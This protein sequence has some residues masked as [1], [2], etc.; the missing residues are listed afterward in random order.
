MAGGR[1]HSGW[2]GRTRRGLLV[3]GL[4]L[5]ATPVVSWWNGPWP[6]PW[7]SIRLEPAVLEPFVDGLMGAQISAYQVPGAVVAVVQ[8]GEVL[9][10]KGYGLARVVSAT[11]VRADQTLF[12]VGSVAKVLTWMALLQLAESG[13]LSL[14]QD[15][16]EHLGDLALPSTFQ[17]PI[18]PSH[19]MTHTAGFED[20]F[21]GIF[22]AGG[23]SL[24]P[25]PDYL[26]QYRPL[27][28]RPPGQLTAYSNYGAALA[29]HLVER[30][31]GL[32]FED[33]V[34]RHI[35]QPLDML[36]ST[37]AQP[38][39][40][41]LRAQLATGYGR[42]LEPLGFEWLQAAPSGALSTT[43]A[44]MA[45]LMLTVLGGGQLGEARVLD[46]AWVETMLTRQFT[47]DPRLPG[48]TFAFQ[49]YLLNGQR[50]LW[51]PGDTLGFSSALVLVP[52]QR[53]GIFIAY[54]RLADSQPRADFL[55]IF[56]D[57]FFPALPTPP[58]A[59]KGA[60]AGRGVRYAGSYLPSRSNL[61][62][63]EKVF[64]LFRPVTVSVLPDGRLHTEGLWAVKEGF[65]LETEPG[66]YR[67]TAGEGV[68][69]FREQ[70][71]RMIMLEGNYPQGAYL[72]V[73][74]YGAHWLHGFT[75]I[76]AAVAFF[77]TLAAATSRLLSFRAA[78]PPASL[79][80][81][82][83]VV[84]V[85]SLVQLG[86]LV[87][88][89]SILANLRALAASTDRLLDALGLLAFLGAVMA[90]AAAVAQGALWRPATGR[91]GWRI[92]YGMVVLLG[93]L[94]SLSL[95]YWRVL[96]VPFH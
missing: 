40:K 1:R 28:V 10:A 95:A 23:G 57:R 6:D 51:H 72:R 11:P 69:H 19:L 36:S 61:S 67:H 71:D 21:G 77:A 43:A 52:D 73:P 16:N 84:E 12:R 29:G 26:R 63:P 90:A 20:R 33:Y 75:W 60:A 87:G 85:M 66:A 78:T 9:L 88:L 35:F 27:R 15:V 7:R 89:L 3:L 59:P 30:V 56:M 4:C 96:P 80:W 81:P 93:L 41:S 53:L 65:W 37:F 94:F 46:R 2:G 76:A 50:L 25:L 74:W 5:A 42:R 68:L 64:K 17:T 54:N 8:H 82:R 38:V 55:K 86:V 31:T 70:Q 14:G 58:P 24:L 39:P 92:W 79:R 34:A 44:D 49:E 47:N 48:L 13:G 91:W 32:R 83:R 62:G 45:R 18:T 22:A